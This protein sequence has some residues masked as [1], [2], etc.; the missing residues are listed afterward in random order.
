MTKA[1]HLD[2][3][4]TGAGHALIVISGE[5]DPVTAPRLREQ[6]MSLLAEGFPNLLLEMSEVDFC[7]SSGLSVVIALWQQAH[8]SGGSLALAAV[9]ARLSRLL[10]MTAMDTLI[11][12]RHVG[13]SV[14]EPS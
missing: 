4:H 14:P 7:D 12:V 2:V 9:P 11:P 5:L 13:G 1:F 10:R 3:R 6:G 8:A